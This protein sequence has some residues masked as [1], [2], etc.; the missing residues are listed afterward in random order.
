M[1]FDDMDEQM[2]RGAILRHINVSLVT[3]AEEQF[4]R[5]VSLSKYSRIILEHSMVT[6]KIP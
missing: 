1:S 3:F 6:C 5:I 4:S 2:E